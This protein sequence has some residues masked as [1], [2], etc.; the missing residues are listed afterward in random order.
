MSLQSVT[1]HAQAGVYR[2]H[3]ESRFGSFHTGDR[4]IVN[5]T[6]RIGPTSYEVRL[7]ENRHVV[8][9]RLAL[10]EG[11]TLEATVVSAGERLELRQLYGGDAP[12]RLEDRVEQDAL[13]RL[14][15]EY[16]LR[17]APADAAVLRQMMAGAEKAA[18][19][20]KTG[21][22]LARLGLPLHNDNLEALYSSHVSQPVKADADES[23]TA[24]LGPV[25]AVGGQD[26]AAATLSALQSALPATE[27]EP[28]SMPGFDA[29]EGG[30]SSG[31]RRFASWVLNLQD[32]GSVQYR[33]G[34]LQRLVNGQLT[35]IDLAFFQDKHLP[36][37]DQSSRR[38][39]MTLHTECL[40]TVRIS[41]ELQ[42]S[43]L[44]VELASDSPEGLEQLGRHDAAFRE[45][46]GQSGWI[47]DAVNYRGAAEIERALTEIV[48]HVLRNGS[49]DRRL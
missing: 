11:Q 33:Y 49:V 10:I 5:V 7:G 21:L 8:E 24:G 19:M 44:T 22:F 27:S 18:T 45:A 20:A 29:G 9:S 48:E 3:A 31:N 4:V 38:L 13:L 41:T 43:H 26:D 40:G 47:L 1:G 39:V 14:A 34:T 25:F 23:E 30:D 36:Q 46:L 15:Q 28:D 2:S 16:R 32:G 12:E 37:P 35:E 17:L 6:R 42:G